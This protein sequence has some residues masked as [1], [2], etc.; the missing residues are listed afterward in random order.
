MNDLKGLALTETEVLPHY[1][2]YLSRFDKFEEV[3][4]DY[5]K[6]KKVQVI[7]LNDGEEYLFETVRRKSVSYAKVIVIKFI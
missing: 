6:E 5:E 7:R 1:S 4:S 3:C 2:K